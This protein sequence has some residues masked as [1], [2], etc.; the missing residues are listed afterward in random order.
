MIRRSASSNVNLLGD[1]ESTSV[2]LL[3]QDEMKPGV[4]IKSVLTTVMRGPHPL[5]KVVK[6]EVLDGKVVLHFDKPLDKYV[7]GN[8][9]TAIILLEVE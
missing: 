4:K 3:L 9:Y 7:D 8:G 5:P 6:G 1:G 2:T